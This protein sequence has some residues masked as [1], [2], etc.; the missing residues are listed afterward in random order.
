MLLLWDRWLGLEDEFLEVI[1]SKS[2]GRYIEKKGF[3]AGI[4]A[5]SCAVLVVVHRLRTK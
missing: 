2:L 1:L 4:E 5:Q 3:V